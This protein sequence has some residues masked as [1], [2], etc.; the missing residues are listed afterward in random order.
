MVADT[1]TQ[2]ILDGRISLEDAIQRFRQPTLGEKVKGVGQ[3]LYQGATSA[4]LKGNA[5]IMD[6]E[7]GALG[8]LGA[9]EASERMK[10]AAQSM[11]AGQMQEDVTGAVGQPVPQLQN[12]GWIGKTLTQDAPNLAG[13]V[14][15]SALVPG[16]RGTGRAAIGVRGAL[17][18]AGQGYHEALAHGADDAQAWTSFVANALIGATAAGLPGLPANA[19]TRLGQI[20]A[21]ANK[22]SGGG[23]G[24]F[25][26]DGIKTGFSSAT[27]GG[28]ATIGQNT[29]AKVLYDDDR[30]F[31][32][33]VLPMVRGSAL[34]G[35]VAGAVAG[36]AEAQ[37]RKLG[38]G[39]PE[40][41]PRGDTTGEGHTPTPEPGSVTRPRL[42]MDQIPPEHAQAVKDLTAGSQA[43][44]W[45]GVVHPV[46]PTEA[47]SPV[48]SF[49]ERRGARLQLVEAEDGQ[50]L[51]RPA[52]YSKD[53]A[54]VAL[55]VN[56]PDAF[57]SLVD[58]EI[59]HHVLESVE[60][61]RESLQATIDRIAPELRAA[62]A[63]EYKA[64]ILR[65]AQKQA[66]RDLT[67]E[68]VAQIEQQPVP[69]DEALTR[70]A[71][72]FSPVVR[73]LRTNPEAFSKIDDVGFWRNFLRSVLDVGRSILKQPTS[74]ER[75]LAEIYR[76]VARTS[77]A[78]KIEPARGVEIANAMREFLD[79]TVGAAQKPVGE[80]PRGDASPSAESAVDSGLPVDDMAAGGSPSPIPEP[81]KTESTTPEVETAR[82]KSLMRFSKQDLEQI[83]DQRL[84]TEQQKLRE[85]HPGHDDTWY[86][87]VEDLRRQARDPENPEGDR[88]ALQLRRAGVK[89]S[90][91]N[92]EEIT[93][94]IR[95]KEKAAAAPK[96]RFG[97]EIKAAFEKI[98]KGPQFA[99]PR[100]RTVRPEQANRAVTYLQDAWRP[101]RK[102]VEAAEKE[103]LV[104]D[105]NNVYQKEELRRGKTKDRIEREAEAHVKPLVDAVK[106]SGMDVDDVEL[107]LLARGAK[108]RNR[109]IEQ[110]TGKIN[111][112]GMSDATAD[113]I[114]RQIQNG[115]HAKE[116]DQ[117]AQK[118]DALNKRTRELWVEYGLED[119]NL[120]TAMEQEQPHFA[121]MRNEIEGDTPR[122]PGRQIQGREFKT[123]LGRTSIAENPLIYATNDLER[124]I[125]RGEDN[126]VKQSL[127]QLA[128]D[129]GDPKL[130]LVDVPPMKD[131][132]VNGKVQKV[133]DF[134]EAE[135]EI[136]LKVN[137]ELRRV[138]FPKEFASIPRAIKNMDAETGGKVVQAMGKATRMIAG[139]S[140]RW[141][142][143]FPPV[144]AAR[145]VLGAAL[146]AKD[147]AF[148]NPAKLYW[149]AKEVATNGP[150]AQRYRKSGA[151]VAYLDLYPQIAK[152]AERLRADV[153]AM[154][155]ELT[156]WQK[157]KRAI[158]PVAR[159]ISN[160][161]DVAEGMT[162]LSA[163]RH[164]IEDLGMSE[165][166]AASFAKNIT[167]N[168]ER[169]GQ[170]SWINSI[171]AFSNAGIQG[172]ARAGQT[173]KKPGAAKL[174]AALVAGGFALDSMNRVA[175]GQ[176]EDGIPYYDK[177]PDYIRRNHA[178]VMLP[179][180][181]GDY[182]KVPLPFVW[183]FFHVA[184][185]EMSKA[186]ADGEVG[187]AVGN[188]FTALVD[189]ANPLG[190][191]GGL[192]DTLTPTLADPLVQEAANKNFTGNPIYP[193]P[194]GP[195]P[196]S[197]LA[198]DD[199]N[200]TLV[201]VT[202]W[203]N[204]ATGGNRA[205]SGLIDISPL[206]IEHLV[207]SY[208]GGVGGE[209]KRMWATA[210]KIASG[211]DVTYADIPIWRRFMGEISEGDQRHVFKNHL[212]LVHE[213][214]RLEH[215]D[216]P[217]DERLY[218]LHLRARA[219]EE[220]VGDLEDEIKAAPGPEK[221][222]LRKEKLAVMLEAIRVIRETQAADGQPQSTAP[223]VNPF[224][225]Q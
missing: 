201:A 48:R 174:V 6:L 223:E 81:Q 63:E 88:A 51:P 22:A 121:P 210:E 191:G 152:Q 60:G 53:G 187:R 127:Y 196:N 100:G 7:G 21:R 164:A 115:P 17:V 58:H 59:G 55:D 181:N 177:I 163:F 199:T 32:E 189:Q 74:Q 140:T 190:S 117:I 209:S 3:S 47:D 106:K 145:D 172:L 157:T 202:R 175:G 203:L 217:Y 111:G 28:L 1:L 150:W 108:D 73:L 176:D 178:I 78:S 129:V 76:S 125:A 219:W 188:T 71:E 77:L 215:L 44:G 132:L 166:Q 9:S 134:Q 103:G 62:A 92:V 224:A 141:N 105:K 85:E 16:P 142:P 31:L 29:V 116:F 185:S 66:G 197:E 45:E 13:A 4:L 95:A 30:Q 43:L 221:Q 126:R 135:N 36:H 143:F 207:Q 56:S 46:E 124:A 97:Q 67:S 162:R 61:S 54:I 123:A 98:G 79:S 165:D 170:A 192:I 104:N 33:G 64:D 49:V 24:G 110:R 19:Q 12:Q 86:Q 206:T 151:P 160:L 83:R 40:N 220:R 146:N 25:L 218:R 194:H 15:G 173:L 82:A 80:V 213:S 182:I 18:G 72:D 144:N 208:L 184:G 171:F 14:L 50:P 212:N 138:R 211:D 107:G 69:H 37:Q 161:N 200:P 154:R 130:M 159:A 57:S 91:V 27:Q 205:K 148:L 11:A 139:L 52:M 34:F 155:G 75:K 153:A 149:A 39:T 147:K 128:R 120:V 214:E 198:W 93:D 42:A 204:A 38:G 225:R 158:A 167:V 180:T 136:T 131:A 118:F 8:L 216:Q 222:A 186:M 65:Q 169:K 168:F 96:G 68:E 26:W 102:L 23:L 70:I 20:L 35:L 183:G 156:P 5:A 10:R 195:T 179:G 193:D 119:Q 133:P 101:V 112:S 99:A 87:R 94:A 41:T 137:G 89:P 114:L 113:K 84:K 2:A 122:G 90:G 109:L